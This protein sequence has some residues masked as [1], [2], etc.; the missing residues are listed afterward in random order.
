MR[1]QPEGLRHDLLQLQ[2]DLEHVLARRE[3]GPVADAEDVRVDRE[4]LLVEGGV[5]HHVSRFPADSRKLLKLLASAGDL[6]VVI[7]HES[8]GQ[9]DDVLRLSVEQAD[10]L[11]GVP[12]AFF[13]ERDH[14]LGRPDPRKQGA[15]RN[16]DAGIRRLRG[17]N[18][19]H[20][21]SVGV[22]IFKLRGRGGV[23]LRQPPE[24]L[25]YLLPLQWQSQ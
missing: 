18:D 4:R 5:E 13:P 1:V 19:R 15:R 14:L 10:R 8:F 22:H 11:D 25:E 16:V 12:D 23:L 7:A 2:L 9:S 21:Q 20:Q 24:K 3:S 17:Q 6:A